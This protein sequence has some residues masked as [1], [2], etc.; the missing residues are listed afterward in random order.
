[1]QLDLRI[2]RRTSTGY[3]YNSI[4]VGLY[5]DGTTTGAHQGGVGAHYYIAASPI[6]ATGTWHHGAVTY[7]SSMLRY[8]LDSSLVGSLAN[9][10]T[11]GHSCAHVLNVD[12]FY[13][14]SDINVD[15]FKIS[16]SV[17]SADWIA[18]EYTNQFNLGTF[19][20]LGA[21]Q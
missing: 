21:E 15:D 18:T 9:T 12:T 16:N 2:G 10:Q 20:S 11:W 14:N 17:R 19:Y 8:Y 3:P 7:D 6:L 5:I 13:R 4:S 1:M